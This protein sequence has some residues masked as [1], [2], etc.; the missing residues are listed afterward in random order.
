MQQDVNHFGL[1]VVAASTVRFIASSDSP[2]L[3]L[4]P[5]PSLSMIRSGLVHRSTVYSPSRSLSNVV[6]LIQPNHCLVSSRRRL[7][8]VTSYRV[9]EIAQERE[10]GRFK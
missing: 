10:R 7:P 1:E 8:T 5:P 6:Y 2:S 9:L 3:R 4:V